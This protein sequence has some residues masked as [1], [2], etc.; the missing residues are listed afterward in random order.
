MTSPIHAEGEYIGSYESFSNSRWA[1]DKEVF[2]RLLN[3]RAD[4]AVI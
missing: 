4:L 3:V 2:P 1:L